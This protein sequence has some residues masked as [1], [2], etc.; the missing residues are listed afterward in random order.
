MQQRPRE[1]PLRSTLL[2]VG[3]K[4]DKGASSVEAWG[5]DGGLFGGALQG[6]VTEDPLGKLIWKGGCCSEK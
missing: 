2:G 5:R 3:G 6:L 1:E 4:E